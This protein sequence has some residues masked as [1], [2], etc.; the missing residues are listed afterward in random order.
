MPA[1]ALAAA[2]RAY[3]VGSN[4]VLITPYHPS[5][6]KNVVEL[7]EDMGYKLVGARH[8]ACAKPTE[9]A[10]TPEKDLR[11]AVVDLNGPHVDAIVQLGANLPMWHVAIEAERW[12][13]K[14]VL[15]INTVAYW[16]ALRTCGI[17]DRLHG[18]GRIMSD[19]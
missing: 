1:D 2:L 9:I 10:Q 13:G 16:H 6:H 5:A 7:I 19:F 17:D 12:L 18:V 4:I 11:Q 8:L 15:A 14:P 3:G